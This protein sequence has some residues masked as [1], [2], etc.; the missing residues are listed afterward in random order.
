MNIVATGINPGS[1]ITMSS[2]E[3]A[4]LVGSRHDKVMQSIERLAERGIFTLPPMGEVPNDGPGPKL[5]KEYRLDKRSSLIVVAQ[6]CPQFT[7][8]IVDRWQELEEQVR[9]PAKIDVRDPSQLATIAIQL[10]EVNKELAHRAE[11]AEEKIEEAKPKT[12]FYDQFANADGLY[13]L[14]NAGRIF[15]NNP[16]KFLQRLKAGYLFYQGGVLMPRV[17]YRDMGLFEVKVE[18]VD[19][20]A[21]PRTFMT[22]KGV[23]YFAKKFGLSPLDGSGYDVAGTKQRALL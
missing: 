20:R 4:D 14:Q 3:I 21:R 7:A 23:Q 1:A 8:R 10:I 18:M 15:S 19:D 6:L 12:T 5:V 16:N 22:P 17:Q 13:G 11:I 9:Q 2:R